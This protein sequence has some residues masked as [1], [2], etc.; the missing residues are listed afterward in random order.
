MR[1]KVTDN[2][3]MLCNFGLLFFLCDRY[4]KESSTKPQ[5]NLNRNYWRLFLFDSI[6]HFLPKSAGTS[7]HFSVSHFSRGTV[8]GLLCSHA[9]ARAMSWN[10]CSV[11]GVRARVVLHLRFCTQMSA[12]RLSLYTGIDM[13]FCFIRAKACTMARNSPM[14][15]VPCTGPKWNTSLP[16]GRCTP[17]YSIGPGLPLQA[18]ST[19]RADSVPALDPLPAP[20]LRG[21]V[22]TSAGC[23]SFVILTIGYFLLPPITQLVT[24]PSLEGGRGEGP[25]T[26]SLALQCRAGPCLNVSPWPRRH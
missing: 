17:L 19:Q 23:I 18:A 26:S 24:A 9:S 16:E 4:N 13:P 25:P 11:C 8:M 3:A 12:V 15:F 5:Q 20:P 6:L 14:L 21:R 22:D 1:R 2:S 10:S 7:P